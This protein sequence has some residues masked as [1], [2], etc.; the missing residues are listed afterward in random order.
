CK[1]YFE[2]YPE[3]HNLLWQVEGVGH[4]FQRKSIMTMW[5]EGKLKTAGETSQNENSVQ[6]E[7]RSCQSAAVAEASGHNTDLE[8]KRSADSQRGK[9]SVDIHASTSEDPDIVPVSIWTR[10]GHLKRPRIG[11]NS[12]ESQPETSQ[13]DEENALHVSESRLE[14]PAHTSENSEDL[15]E[16]PAEDAVEEDKEMIVANEGQSVSEAELHVSPREKG[17]E[18]E[19]TP[20]EPLNGEVV[21]ETGKTSLM[22]EEETANEVVSGES[23]LQS[24]S[25]GEEPL[26]LFVPLILE[27]QAKPAEDTASQKALNAHD[28]E[29]LTE[30]SMFVEK[31]GTGEQQESEK[32]STGNAAALASKEEEPSDNGLPN[33]VVNEAA[34]ESGFENVSPKTASSLE[35]QNEEPGHNSQESPVALSQSSLIVVELEGVSFQQPSGPEGQKNQ[36]EEHLEESAEQM[37][38]YTQ[39]AAERAADS[40]SE[41]AEIEVPIVDRRNLRRKAKGYKGPPKKKGKTA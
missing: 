4:W 37:D 32:T 12:Q 40:S 41:E 11:K 19:E 25:Q 1:Q 20:S 17:S 38:Q 6:A 23:K 13:E 24:E 18:K 5:Q 8:T 10:S 29:E 22:A 15:P 39:T 27:S 14:R 35:D 9:E 28:S 26:M 21:E 31:E 33:S 3:K 36:L 2:K 34:E 16:V 7:D 30:A